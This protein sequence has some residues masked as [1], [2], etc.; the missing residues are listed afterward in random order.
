MSFGAPYLA[1]KQCKVHFVR[2]SVERGKMT[3][4]LH[5]SG[6]HDTI[7]AM[8]TGGK[9]NGFWSVLAGM[10]VGNNGAAVAAAAAEQCV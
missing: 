6:L 2:A 8:E 3:G 5:A 4:I 10:Q 7:V 1:I 9:H